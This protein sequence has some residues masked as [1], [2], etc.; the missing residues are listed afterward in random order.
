MKGWLSK[1][2]KRS[3]AK[4]NSSDSSKPDLQQPMKRFDIIV[5]E[6]DDKGNKI[7]HP[8]NGVYA[9]SRRELIE[10]YN[11][12]QQTIHILREYDDSPINL[13]DQTI[14]DKKQPE[15]KA[16]NKKEVASRA[17][18]VQ[19]KTVVEEPKPAA[20][21]YF[22]IAGIDCKLEN[23]KIY[24]KQWVKLFGNEAN[25]YRL[26]S[27]SNNKEIS[28]N[29]KHLEVLKWILVEDGNGND[30]ASSISGIING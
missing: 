12:C 27:D 21:K 6:L 26:I 4:K 14:S 7:Q 17:E 11:D 25:Q 19:P 10:L 1:I 9:S 5:E 13:K 29:G 8:E 18:V 28:M 3:T 22:Q 30:L 16:P 2:F 20:P 15:Q 24:Q 23:G